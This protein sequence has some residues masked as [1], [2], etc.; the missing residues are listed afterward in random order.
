M[1]LE[2]ERGR[3]GAESAR[4]AE[5]ERTLRDSIAL[6]KQ[7]LYDKQSETDAVYREARGLRQALALQVGLKVW[8]VCMCAWGGAPTT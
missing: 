8:D 6:Y 2:E 3:S 1:Q 5:L 7:D 4:R